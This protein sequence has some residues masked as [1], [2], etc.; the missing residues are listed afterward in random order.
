[1]IFIFILL[2]TQLPRKFGI[3]D[4]VRPWLLYANNTRASL[5]YIAEIHEPKTSRQSRPF[6]ASHYTQSRHLPS[7]FALIPSSPF[8]YLAP[9]ASL[10]TR[11]CARARATGMGIR[12]HLLQIRNIVWKD[13][14]SPRDEHTREPGLQSM[15]RAAR[16]WLRHS[17]TRRPAFSISFTFFVPRSLSLSLSVRR[18]E[19]FL[20]ARVNRETGEA[21]DISARIVAKALF[22]GTSRKEQLQFASR[23]RPGVRPALCRSWIDSIVICCATTDYSLPFTSP[24]LRLFS[25]RSEPI[26]DS[27][28]FDP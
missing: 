1:M 24:F 8:D 4:I 23:Y 10:S 22:P 25:A 17:S 16:G 12:R 3:F 11:R 7:P 5:V 18:E 9:P 6:F 27:L 28:R 2:L 13:V 15:G 19:I 20:S 26:E 14:L 21:A